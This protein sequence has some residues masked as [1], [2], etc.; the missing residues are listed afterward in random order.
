M[1][2]TCSEVNHSVKS[3]IIRDEGKERRGEGR[4]M[5]DEAHCDER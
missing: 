4:W 3:L 2:K 5:K 1:R